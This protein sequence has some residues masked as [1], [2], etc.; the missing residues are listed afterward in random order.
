VI[1]R[2]LTGLTWNAR[3][4]TALD[5]PRTRRRSMPWLATTAILVVV[6]FGL[7][8]VVGLQRFGSTASALAYLRGDGLI[9]DEYTKSFGTASKS[10]RPSVTFCIK[11][12]SKQPIKILGGKSSCTCVIAD[13]LPSVVLPNGETVVRVSASRRGRLGQYSEQIR[14]LTNSEQSLLILTVHGVFL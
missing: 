7:L 6:G 1:L 3:G 14:L 9:P 5:M 4:A 11:N 10:E 12:F 13:G 2:T 8:F